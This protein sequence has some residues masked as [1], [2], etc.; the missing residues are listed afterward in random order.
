MKK[1]AWILIILCVCLLASGCKD[2]NDCSCTCSCENCIC[3]KSEQT[4]S[5]E[6]KEE[7]IKMLTEEELKEQVGDQSYQGTLRQEGVIIGSIAEDLST[8]KVFHRSAVWEM[9]YIDGFQTNE[10]RW[11]V[12]ADNGTQDDYSDDIFLSFILA[13]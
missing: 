7:T 4:A 13:E 11:A 5:D 3:E 6:Q 1:K 8:M 2:R 9:D 12:I 10:S